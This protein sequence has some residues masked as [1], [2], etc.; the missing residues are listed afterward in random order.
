MRRLKK[1]SRPQN[2]WKLVIYILALVVLVLKSYVYEL[3]WCINS[4]WAALGRA[5]LNVLLASR[6]NVPRLRSCCW[7][8]HF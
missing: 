5:L 1:S 7:T 2:H 4:E 3:K 8:E 6:I